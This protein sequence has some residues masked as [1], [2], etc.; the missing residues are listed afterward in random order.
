MPCDY[1]VHGCNVAEYLCDA[2]VCL[3]TTTALSI[4]VAKL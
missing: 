2:G 3:S 4:P 1:W